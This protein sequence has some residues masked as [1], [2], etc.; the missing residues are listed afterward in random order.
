MMGKK[1]KKEEKS[2]KVVDVAAAKA[3]EKAVEDA[4]PKAP[5]S[6]AKGCSIISNKRVVLSPG[7]AVAVGDVASKKAFDTLMERGKIVKN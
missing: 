5:Y 4:T 6:V 3:A 1:D 2:Q 7:D